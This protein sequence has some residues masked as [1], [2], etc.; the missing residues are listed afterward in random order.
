VASNGRRGPA[1]VTVVRSE[2]PFEEAE[3]GLERAGFVA[4]GRGGLIAFG[5]TSASVEV[6]LSEEGAGQG[7][8][9]GDAR[10]TLFEELGEAPVGAVYAAGATA[11][12][13]CPRG[14]AI[15]YEVSDG[16]GELLLL[17]E[18]PD[19]GLFVLDDAA[20][21]KGLSVAASFKFGEPHADGDLLRVPFTYPPDERGGPLALLGGG[22]PPAGFYACRGSGAD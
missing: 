12:S 19:P 8:A 11:P 15:G 1:A 22:T 4:A 2:Q 21:V 3:A 7:G 14:I 13:Q 20:G 6:A 5:S 10:A 18:A 16:V 9:A 17:V